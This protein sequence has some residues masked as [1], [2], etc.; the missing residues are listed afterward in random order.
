MSVC[1]SHILE[2][3]KIDSIFPKYVMNQLQNKL[4]PI[5]GYKHKPSRREKKINKNGKYSITDLQNICIDKSLRDILIYI[6]MS[7]LTP[8]KLCLENT[9]LNV[10]NVMDYMCEHYNYTP[11]VFTIL[12]VPTFEKRYLLMSRF[13]PDLIT[14]RYDVIN[15]K[16][17]NIVLD[18]VGE[19]SDS[20]PDTDSDPEPEIK[21]KTTKK[22][23]V[24]ISSDESSD[25]E[26]TIQKH[27]FDDELINLE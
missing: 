10:N 5:I 9:V 14:I 6:N 2:S 15:D 25:E 11:D 4:H 22:I 1:G 19:V 8:D 16:K 21:K 3:F 17:T 23:I 26:I 27:K 24:N 18:N 12:K 7:K 13:Y 20:I